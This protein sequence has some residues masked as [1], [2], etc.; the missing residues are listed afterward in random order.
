[1]HRENK[2]HAMASLVT[3]GLRGVSKNYGSVVAVKPLDLDIH[4]GDFLAILGPSGCGKT[5]L[6]RMIG[7]FLAPSH[8]RITVRG[9]DVT[10]QPP[11]HRPTNMVFQGYGL[12]P[13]MTVKQNIAYGLKLKRI[14][15]SEVSKR[16]DRMLGLTKLQELAERMPNQLSGGQQQRVAV[17]RALV[18]EPPV[19][20]LDEP[21]SA[22]DL[23]LR[24][25][26]QTELRRIHKEV[27]GTFVFVTHDQGEAM[28]LA[29]RVAVMNEGRVE[30]LGTPEDLYL[31]PQSRFVAQFV[32][33]ANILNGLRSEGQVQLACGAHFPSPGGD[34]AVV[35]VVRPENL[36]LGV[37]GLNSVA[38]TGRVE[39]L[40]FFGSYVR[41]L[42]HLQSGEKLR[43]HVALGGT[44][45]ALGA[46][47]TVSWLLDRTIVLEED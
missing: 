14:A 29:N 10:N 44:A 13:H 7:G 39:D 24:H 34:G 21:F 20:L 1:M 31:R 3:V 4:A 37:Q 16:V 9:E 8:G 45:A 47:V 40:T 2:K 35:A 43:A 30:Q 41:Y 12:F 11:E 46:E 33:E 17:A 36:T 18:M 25:A 15:A 27:G 42:V 23:K 22:L 28:A 38:I 26:M 5:T 19:L 32:G 6:L